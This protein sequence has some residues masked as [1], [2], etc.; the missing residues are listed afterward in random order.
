MTEDIYGPSVPYLKVKTVHHKVQHVETIIVPYFPK[1]ILD[2]YKEI[3]LCCDLMHITG[4]GF[5]NTISWHIMVAT[6][7]TIK[8]KN[9]IELDMEANRSKI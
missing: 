1:V 3:P 4:I 2:R 7:S 6:G 9:R 5:L 8:N